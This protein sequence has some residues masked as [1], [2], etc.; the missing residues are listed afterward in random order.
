MRL[1]IF[2]LVIFLAYIFGRGEFRVQ[3][4]CTGCLK[5]DNE[6]SVTSW[7]LRRPDVLD[8]M[9]DEYVLLPET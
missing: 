1:S 8:P 5:L 2:L 9:N 3:F 7:A 4:E 6:K